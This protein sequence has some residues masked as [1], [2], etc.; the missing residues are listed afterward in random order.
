MAIVRQSINLS[1]LR[2]RRS[3]RGQAQID[4]LIQKLIERVHR[5]RQMAVTRD[6]GPIVAMVSVPNEKTI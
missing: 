6:D 4:R 3:L 1:L 2:V 5:R